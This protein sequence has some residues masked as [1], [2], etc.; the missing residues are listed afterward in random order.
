MKCVFCQGKLKKGTVPFHI[1]RKGIHITFDA[2]PAYVCQQCGQ[3]MFDE[4]ATES[5]E[6]VVDA[7]DKKTRKRVKAA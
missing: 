3:A 7:F 5:I 2:I 1:D 6:E 4:K